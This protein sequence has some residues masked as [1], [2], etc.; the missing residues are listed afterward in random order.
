MPDKKW[1]W[2]VMKRSSQQNN[3][4]DII[5]QI[6]LL[7]LASVITQIGAAPCVSW[8]RSFREGQC[9]LI[10]WR[11]AAGGVAMC[12]GGGKHRHFCLIRFAMTVMHWVV[13][14][15][16]VRVTCKSAER[17]LARGL[18][19]WPPRPDFCCLGASKRKFLPWAENKIKIFKNLICGFAVLNLVLAP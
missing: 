12:V 9:V 2:A 4:R 18:I 3:H 13:S 14:I 15:K 11:R 19:S 5:K 16:S 17:K 6:K 1:A 7:Q 8:S 10:S